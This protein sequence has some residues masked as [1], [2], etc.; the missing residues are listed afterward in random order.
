MKKYYAVKQGRRCGVFHSWDECKKQVTGFPGAV[1]KSFQ[2][3]DEALTFTKGE[4][5]SVQAGGLPESDQADLPYAY[6]D[7][8]FNAASGVYGYG[9]ILVTEEGSFEFLGSGS[10][11]EMVSMRNVAGEIE[12]SMRAVMEAVR[13]GFKKLTI[14]YD[15][16][17]IECW[18]NGTWKT[19]KEGTKKYQEYMQLQRKQIQLRFCKVAAHTGVEL[20]E[21]VDQLAKKAAGIR[22]A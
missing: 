9:V 1:F 6:V 8:S 13:L 2:S 4:Q 15:Y 7:G 14:Y 22:Q 12:G 10:D 19:N 20:N 3:Y 17:G 16:M 11:Q 18:A 5:G 21:A